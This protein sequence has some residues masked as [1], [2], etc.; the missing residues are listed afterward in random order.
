[1]AMGMSYDEYWHGENERIA[2]YREAYKRKKEAENAMLWRQGIYEK[3][4]IMSA[5][6]GED[7]KYP[8]E[9]L[10]MSEE[11]AERQEE[12]RFEAKKRE[13]MQRMS[14]WAAKSKNK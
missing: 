14:A 9:P 11:E 1:M 4:A 10:P 13:A 2:M 5:F 3:Y 8:D 6:G 12:R 7:C